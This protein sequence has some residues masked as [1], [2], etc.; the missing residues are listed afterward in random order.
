M[1]PQNHTLR[2]ARR[3]GGL[4]VSKATYMPSQATA[5]GNPIPVNGLK[6]LN[7]SSGSRP[8][9]SRVQVW[10][11]NG[12]LFGATAMVARG[13]VASGIAYPDNTGRRIWRIKLVRTA[14]S[15]ERTGDPRVTILRQYA[16]SPTCFLEVLNYAKQRLATYI[17]KHIS[18]DDATRLKEELPYG[19]RPIRHD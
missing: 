3:R 4:A 18:V 2:S 16:S 12:F 8:F 17:P 1:V 14:A 11:S 19:H 5:P 13:L 6:G 7:A 10:T 9:T 15:L